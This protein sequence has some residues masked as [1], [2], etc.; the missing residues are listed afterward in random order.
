MAQDHD[1][2]M[3][4]SY[5]PGRAYDNSLFRLPWEIREQIYDLLMPQELI[6][7]PV[8]GVAIASISRLPPSTTWL[9][10]DKRTSTEIFDYFMD[11]TTWRIVVRYSYNF[12]R[13][14][15]QMNGLL[16]WPRLRRLERV[17]LVCV[18]EQHFLESYPSLGLEKYCLDTATSTLRL[19]KALARNVHLRVVTIC[20]DDTTVLS[21]WNHKCPIFESL[22]ALASQ[23]PVKCGKIT[24][25]AATHIKKYI[26][27]LEDQEHVM[28][29]ALKVSLKYDQSSGPT[30]LY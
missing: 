11:R 4:Q 3:A 12:F 15:A 16:A 25:P 1:L 6:L 5:D 29:E 28:R 23:C 26:Q 22:S 10:I 8:P 13:H 2:I 19:S 14:D 17:D 7:H 18:I 20:V 21:K 24:S 27:S 9:L 30:C